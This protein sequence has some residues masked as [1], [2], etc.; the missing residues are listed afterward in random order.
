MADWDS[1]DRVITQTRCQ[2]FQT[3]CRA[4]ETLKSLKKLRVFDNLVC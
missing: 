4:F 2:A 1:M 3:L